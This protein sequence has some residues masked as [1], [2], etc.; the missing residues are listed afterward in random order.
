MNSTS[1]QAIAESVTLLAQI[2][3][4]VLLLALKTT[5]GCGFELLHKT[6]MFVSGVS[7]F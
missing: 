6:V 3:L 4:S 1:S 7:A 2:L 5:S